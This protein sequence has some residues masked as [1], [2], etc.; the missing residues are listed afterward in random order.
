M[1]HAGEDSNQVHFHEMLLRLS[2]A[3]CSI[4]DW[5][6]LLLQTPAHAENLAEFKDALRLHATLEAVAEHNI[7]QL[8][9]LGQ[10]VAA[11]E[12]VHSSPNASKVTPDDAGGLEAAIF[13][14]VQG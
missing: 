7:S 2:N 6:N 5:Q 12:A 10:P 14:K 4:E 13:L 1:R 8:H 9:V 3:K 11:I